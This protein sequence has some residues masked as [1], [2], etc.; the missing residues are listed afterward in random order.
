MQNACN[1]SAS[2]KAHIL[3]TR[4]DLLDPSM[5][6]LVEAS[7]VASTKETDAA[8]ILQMLLEHRQSQLDVSQNSSMS[9]VLS[10]RSDATVDLEPHLDLSVSRQL[11]TRDLSQRPAQR[12]RN[13]SKATAG[14]ASLTIDEASPTL[15]ERSAVKWAKPYQKA[16]NSENVKGASEVDNISQ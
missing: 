4:S 10:D 14:D 12:G 8:Q 1:S 9:S 2:F 7:M 5:D 11:T 6:M 16:V 15:E 3:L 13:K